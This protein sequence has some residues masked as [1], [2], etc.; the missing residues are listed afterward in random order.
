MSTR[1]ATRDRVEVLA[2]LPAGVIGELLSDPRW[3][4]S[5][6][7]VRLPGGK[8]EEGE[9]PEEAAA[10]E[11]MEEYGLEIQPRDLRLVDTFQ[12]PRGQVVRLSYAGAQPNWLG[13][14]DDT[15][16]GLLVVTPVVPQPWY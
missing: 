7:K 10:R 13:R 1:D 2:E 9:S 5:I 11:L 4:D 16:T 8:I 14:R 3:P 6:G 12:G 15:G